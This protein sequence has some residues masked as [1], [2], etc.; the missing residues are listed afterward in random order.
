MTRRYALKGD[1]SGELL[2]VG[3][4]VLVHDN[5]AE[6]EFLVA[7]ARAVELGGS[8]PAELT[9]PLRDHPELAAVSWPLNRTDFRRR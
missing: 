6:M 2:S 3:G 5:A 1:R 9:M 7:G 4:R 8:F